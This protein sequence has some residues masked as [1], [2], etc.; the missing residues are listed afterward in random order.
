MREHI[1]WMFYTEQRQHLQKMNQR[2]NLWYTCARRSATRHSSNRSMSKRA[3][4]VRTYYIRVHFLITESNCSS[5]ASQNHSCTQCI[6]S[7]MKT[8]AITELISFWNPLCLRVLLLAPCCHTFEFLD[9]YMVGLGRR[10]LT[11][12]SMFITDIIHNEIF[13]FLWIGT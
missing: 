8:V 13:D 7:I 1:T 6:Q 3:L 5:N 12:S 11:R 9:K 4:S 2:Q 10:A